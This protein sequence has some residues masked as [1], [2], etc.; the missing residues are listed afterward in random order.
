MATACCL[1][2]VDCNG[3]QWLLSSSCAPR[4][5]LEGSVWTSCIYTLLWTACGYRA[6]E[7]QHALVFGHKTEASVESLLLV[8][9]TVVPHS[10]ERPT[11]R[12]QSSAF[13]KQTYGRAGLRACSCSLQP[14]KI[15]AG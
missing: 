3:Y 7:G 6:G 8:G 10:L 14:C 9:R 5:D 13:N 4:I 15:D 12:D 11:L 2:A 1:L